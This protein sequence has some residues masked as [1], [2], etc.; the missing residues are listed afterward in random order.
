MFQTYFRDI[1]KT[2]LFF[3]FIFTLI[4]MHDNFMSGF[5]VAGNRVTPF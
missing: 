5:R 2:T 3:V 1:N 4:F